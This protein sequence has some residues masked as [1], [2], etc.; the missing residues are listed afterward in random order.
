VTCQDSRDRGIFLTENGAALAW[1]SSAEGERNFNYHLE[2]KKQ[3]TVVLPSE[4]GED[5]DG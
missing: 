2:F 3:M 1:S 4:S 5:M